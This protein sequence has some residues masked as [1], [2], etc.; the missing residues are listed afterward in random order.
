MTL[1]SFS[2]GAQNY[3]QR[4]KQRAQEKAQRAAEEYE[5]IIDEWNLTDYKSFINSY[6]NSKRIP[7]IKSRVAE[8]ENWEKACRENTIAAYEN[9]LSK[10]TFKHYEDEAHGAIEN[11]MREEIDNAWTTAQ[12]KNTIEGYE[13]FVEKYPN[14]SYAPMARE[15]LDLLKADAA[16]KDVE[17]S[18]VVA[19]LQNF[20]DTYPSYPNVKTLRVRIKAINGL[21]YY[22]DGQLESAAAEFSGLDIND[23][24]DATY[25]EA[26]NATREI[27]DF[28]LLSEKSPMMDLE[29]F[30]ASYP[31]SR[32][33][34]DVN[35]YIALQIADSFNLHSGNW[36]YDRAR[37][38]ASGDTIAIVESRIA[39]NEDKKLMEKRREEA[40]LR[41]QEERRKREK[42]EQR[43]REAYM[44]KLNRD[45]NGGLITMGIEYIDFSLA[46]HNPVN[47]LNYNFG[48]KFQVGNNM[49]RVQAGVTV[50]A[51][52]LGYIHDK[53]KQDLPY[54]RSSYN[55][56]DDKEKSVE[57]HFVLPLEVY[58][59]INLFKT[60][61]KNWC[62]L[63][64]QFTYNA[65]G[66]REFVRPYAWGAGIGFSGKHWNWT[67][68]YKREIG[69]Y[70]P[71]GRIITPQNYIGTSL[72]AFFKLY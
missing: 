67:F 52:V 36:E 16:W 4:S 65:I 70:P 51:G 35:N 20:I 18:F 15:R 13:K 37:S 43:R 22:N 69:D 72:S 71:G 21:R 44:R 27:N 41:E 24:P 39:S 32:Y 62:Y 49:D 60:G 58:A 28:K 10:S 63:Q 54:P 59:K 1:G 6:P 14:C 26:F 9:Y 11:L 48:L 40:R 42:E 23:L 31:N 12:S 3:N 61:E 7:E 64:G 2:A 8:M 45:A 46:L 55:D 57:A 68:Y 33:M 30:K 50:K 25:Y 66:D 56:D 17:S 47:L 34:N 38:F 5:D 53:D 29:L 19:D